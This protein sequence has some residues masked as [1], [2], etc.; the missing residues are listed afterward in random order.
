[1]SVCRH[2]CP[3]FIGIVGGVLKAIRPASFSRPQC[4]SKGSRVRR[5]VP[6]QTPRRARRPDGPGRWVRAR[7]RARGLRRPRPSPETGSDRLQRPWSRLGPNRCPLSLLLSGKRSRERTDQACQRRLLFLRVGS[8]F[9]RCRRRRRSHTPCSVGF[10]RGLVGGSIQKRAKS[11][12]VLRSA[13]ACDRWLIPNSAGS[14]QR[15]PTRPSLIRNDGVVGSSPTCG[16][17]TSLK[18]VP[19]VAVDQ[20]PRGP[21]SSWICRDLLRFAPCRGDA[22]HRA[23]KQCVA[24]F[25]GDPWDRRYI[26]R[27][28]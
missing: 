19:W 12:Q 18:V 5:I 17:S 7:V 21:P 22:I 4:V 6:R 8:I 2:G 11:F 10:S 23:P 1:L 16:T 25:D 28:H 14:L 26:S 9:S 13:T 3:A 24:N 15:R 27:R 20:A